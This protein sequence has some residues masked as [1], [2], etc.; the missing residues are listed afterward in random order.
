MATTITAVQGDHIVSVIMIDLTL[1]NTTYYLSNAYKPV[2]YDGNTYTELGSFLGMN[3]M[4]D[5]IKATN[6]DLSISLSGIPSDADYM[7]IVLTT[8]IKG[9]EV[10]VRRGFMDKN[11]LELDTSQV[12]T[13]Y[14]GIITNFAI[15]E[16]VDI[17]TKQNTNSITITVSSINALLETKVKGQFTN[18][19]NR[20]R[21]FPNDQI[22]NRIPDLQNLHFDFGKEFKSG[23]NY[24]GGGAGGGGGGGGGGG[25]RDRNQRIQER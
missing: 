8:N 5:D 19:E 22:F 13:R 20:K 15:T 10:I 21:I 7:N 23:G 16:D 6:G 2:T 3:A 11:D 12:F 24:G 25:N 18:P 14:S 4:V 9:G 1:D 17:L